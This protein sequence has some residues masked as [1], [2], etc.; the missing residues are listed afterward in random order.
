VG[1]SE[2]ECLSSSLALF[3]QQPTYIVLLLKYGLKRFKHHLQN[4]ENCV[5]Y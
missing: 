4:T 1:L 2:D 5:L 3:F